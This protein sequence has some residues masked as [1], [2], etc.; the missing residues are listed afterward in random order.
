MA[1]FRPRRFGHIDRYG[2]A[3]RILASRGQVLSRRYAGYC[4]LLRVPCTASD[5]IFLKG[6]YIV[7]AIILLHD[8]FAPHPFASP[9]IPVGGDR[10]LKA[11]DEGHASTGEFVEDD[12]NTSVPNRRVALIPALSVKFNGELHPSLHPLLIIAADERPPKA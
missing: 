12:E 7:L 8:I 4:G 9:L 11:V 3:D 1:L 6:L 2:G 5:Y 10:S